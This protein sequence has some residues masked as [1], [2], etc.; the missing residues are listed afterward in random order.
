MCAFGVLQL[1]AFKIALL[2]TPKH[3]YYLDSSDLSFCM[4][5]VKIGSVFYHLLTLVICSCLVQF[6]LPETLSMLQKGVV[7]MVLL[8]LS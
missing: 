7:Y 6:I 5:L 3:I 1:H 2:L 4:Y 8:N